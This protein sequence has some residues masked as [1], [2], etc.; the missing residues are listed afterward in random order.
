LIL[1][2]AAVALLD[3]GGRNDGAADA[4]FEHGTVSSRFFRLREVISDSMKAA[5]KSE[6]MLAVQRADLATDG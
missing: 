4:S 2:R 5:D 1:P 3:V 6:R